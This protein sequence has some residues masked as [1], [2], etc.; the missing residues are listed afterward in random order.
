VL[1]LRRRDVCKERGY[2]K[3]RRWAENCK[4]RCGHPTMIR[5]ERF[6]AATINPEQPIAVAVL[7]FGIDYEE[8]SAA[9]IEPL[10]EVPVLISLANG[11]RFRPQ[12]ERP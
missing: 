8:G 9:I 2:K 12:P 7:L 1:G 3:L 4:S 5:P 11:G 6:T 10:V